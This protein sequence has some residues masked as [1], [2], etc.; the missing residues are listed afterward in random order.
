LSD[1]SK[2]D[3]QPDKLFLV[4]HGVGD[5]LPG[6]TLSLFTR[7]LAEDDNP[8]FEMQETI[9]LQEKSE[10]TAHVKTFPAH[11]RK[12][13]YK[14]EQ[15]ELAEVFW[16]DLSRVRRGVV[17]LI[18]GL[19]QILFG[20]R[21]VAYVAADQ[22]GQAAYWL[23][24]LGLQ[25]SRLLHGPVLA[26]TFHLA[27]IATAV[28]G[29]QLMWN[30]SYREIFWTQIILG[31]CAAVALVTA[32]I[33]NRI[34]NSRVVKRFWYWVNITT[35]FIVGLMLVKHLW[36][37]RYFPNEVYCCDHPG[38]IWYCRVLVIL[39][40]LFWFVQILALAAMACCW[41]F[42]LLHPKAFRPA[43][44]WA[45]LL[46]AF[47]VGIWG[48]AL[49][50]IWVSA[51][52]GIGKFMTMPEFA[53]VFDEAIPLLGVQF[54]MMIVVGAATCFVLVRY[55]RARARISVESFRRGERV[56]RLIINRFQQLTL[57]GCTAVGVSL[58]F[59]LFLWEWM[60]H[61]YHETYVGEFM[62]ETN[63]YAV[64]VLVPLVGILFLVLPYLRA[65]FDIL[66]DVVNHFYF[67]PT[68]LTDALDDD[69]EFDIRE[70]TFES[71]SL[72]FSRRDAI[73][74]RIKRIMIHYRDQYQHRPE[75]VLVSHS[76][77]SMSAIE[78]LNDP[79][80]DWIRGSFGKITLVTMGSPVTNLY[81]HYFKHLYPGFRSPFWTTFH[82]SVD[83]W[84][85]IFRIDDFVG[86]DIEFSTP[87]TVSIQESESGCAIDQISSD[88]SKFSIHR[89]DLDCVEHV[90]TKCSNHPVGSRGHV[91]YWSDF[92]VLEILRKQLL[93]RSATSQ[94]RRAA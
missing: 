34:T 70:T 84:V 31:C 12:L 46:P 48:Q 42:A 41:A 53:S 27:I 69:D 9:W 88:W 77:G 40:G 20:I 52:D 26:I 25:S 22:P 36:L 73:H 51:K 55:L 18:V 67:R 23:K 35:F 32:Q 57:A 92:E 47:A 63:K 91:N 30:D 14:T 49:P 28:I 72:F 43:L 45:F 21:Y 5:P 54:L 16:G 56:P 81:Q 13:Q 4:I 82:K 37:D 64:G 33:G 85:N 24:R 83:R 11:V 80:M 66:L 61:S 50:M 68:S 87:E 94:K 89:N 93:D 2:I 3:R 39:L 38:L 59:L 79:E 6:E 17:G 86:L 10:H 76:Q 65:G 58:V 78:V 62:A 60:G 8:L 15:V 90:P 75:L 1:D 74:G 71:G 29:T 19:F 44:H 7:S